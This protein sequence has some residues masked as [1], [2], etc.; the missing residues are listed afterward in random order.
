MDN[1][2]STEDRIGEKA[3]LETGKAT[4]NQMRNRFLGIFKLCN[5]KVNKIIHS[6]LVRLIVI[7]DEATIRV[8]DQHASTPAGKGK[9]KIE[10]SLHQH[11]WT[12]SQNFFP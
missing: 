1:G 5:K 9:K 2:E 3:V 8:L 11:Q 12:S 7:A 6:E 4:L 10:D